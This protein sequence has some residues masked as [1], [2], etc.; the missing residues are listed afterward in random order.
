MA[1][2]E[3]HVNNPRRSAGGENHS[4]TGCSEGA[5]HNR[6]KVHAISGRPA[7]G[8]KNLIFLY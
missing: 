7:H 2:S 8:L 3:P 4:S 6:Y 1:L 5:Q